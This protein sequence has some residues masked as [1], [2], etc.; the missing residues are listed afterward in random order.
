MQNV[1]TNA[2]THNALLFNLGQAVTA[3]QAAVQ[4]IQSEGNGG[5]SSKQ[6]GYLTTKDMLPAKLSKIE[7]NTEDY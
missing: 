2:M 1:E 3:I 7:V 6:V 5:N 4:K